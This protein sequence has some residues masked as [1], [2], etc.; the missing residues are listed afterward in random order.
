MSQRRFLLSP[1]ELDLG[2]AAGGIELPPAEAA[3]AKNVL[4]LAPG[5][6]VFLLD[7]AG[8]EVRAIL[9][10]VTKR[11]V[12]CQ[13]H[14]VRELTPLPPTLVLCP[15]LLKGP[16]MDTLAAKLTE[17]AVDQVRPFTSQ[18]SVVD[19]KD[20]AGRLERWRRLSGQAL[21]Q[22]N[23]PRRPFWAA[24]LPLAELLDQAPAKAARLL[25]YENEDGRSL[26][27]CLSAA[28]PAREVWLLVG[29]EGGFAPEEAALAAARGFT[30]CGL[31][32]PIAR[33]ETASLTAA[34]VVRYGGWDL[35]A[36]APSIS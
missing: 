32:G 34:A 22:C 33:A 6:E 23:A 2:L 7:G 14:E 10:E 4:R 30:L 21:K 27:A 9:R 8:R 19:L 24:P 12:S 25:L 29:P 3:H 5:A 36:E 20:P 17:L 35:A 16:G 11:R 15:G 28:R 31:P 1:E 18:R 26:A 13:P